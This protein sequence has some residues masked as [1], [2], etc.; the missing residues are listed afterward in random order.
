M[1]HATQAE[2]I[3][4]SIRHSQLENQYNHASLNTGNPIL[5]KVGSTLIR[6]TPAIVAE[7]LLLSAL[8][9]AGIA[10][11]GIVYSAEFIG[12]FHRNFEGEKKTFLDSLMAAGLKV[13]FTI[14]IDKGVPVVT[15]V[16][17]VPQSIYKTGADIIIPEGV[18]SLR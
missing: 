16:L 4:L 5:D 18:N 11:N 9:P 13:G 10:Y 17:G 14:V 12:E 6:D 1:S 8:G 2:Q 15:E 3:N 7:H